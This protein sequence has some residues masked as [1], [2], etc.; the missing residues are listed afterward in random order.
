MT[1]VE[2]EGAYS[3]YRRGTSTASV[4]TTAPTPL[5]TQGG[6]RRSTVRIHLKIYIGI[7]RHWTTWGLERRGVSSGSRTVIVRSGKG[8]H[9]GDLSDLSRWAVVWGGGLR[10]L[11]GCL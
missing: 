9:R 5:S 4:R 7:S 11:H 10:W 6:E 8:V 1:A 3:A 2:V